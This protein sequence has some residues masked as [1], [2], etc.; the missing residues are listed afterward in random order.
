[1]K[2]FLCLLFLLMGCLSFSQNDEEQ[3][4]D[5]YYKRGEFQKALISYQK[6]YDEPLLKGNPCTN[7]LHF[8][9]IL[10]QLL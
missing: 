3:L 4:A 1:M 9:Q 10:H 2:Q 6:L 8:H 7:V 5:D